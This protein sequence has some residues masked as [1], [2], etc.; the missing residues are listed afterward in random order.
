MVGHFY[1][2][3]GVSVEI[4]QALFHPLSETHLVLLTS[5][6]ALRMYNVARDVAIPELELNLKSDGGRG[7]ASSHVRRAGWVGFCFGAAVGWDTFC[8]YILRSDGYIGA[9]CPVVPHGAIV[10]RALVQNL[11]A[12]ERA[13]GCTDSARWLNRTFFLSHQAPNDKNPDSV[14]VA[15]PA[16]PTPNLL[17]AALQTLGFSH[18]SQQDGRATSIASFRKSVIVPSRRS[19]PRFYSFFDVFIMRRCFACVQTGDGSGTVGAMF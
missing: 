13:L 7:G 5:D 14:L 16:V 3:L 15:R 4:I 6:G 17:K 8:I 11:I 9:L 1:H 10:P 19:R 12:V 18:Q 2:A